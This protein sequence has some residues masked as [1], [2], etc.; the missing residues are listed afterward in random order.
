[1]YKIVDEEFVK[2]CVK[3][4]RMDSHKGENGVVLV[5]GGGW[6]YHGAPFL[7]A[8]A[9]LRCGV[10]LAY[11]AAPEKIVPSIRALSPAIIAIPLTDLKPKRCELYCG[12]RGSPIEELDEEPPCDECWRVE[13]VNG[14]LFCEGCGRWYPII[15]EI[16]RM[17]PDDLRDRNED[18]RFL[19]AWRARIPE[20]ILRE[21]KPF[22]L[23]G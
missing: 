9:A 11:I 22:S 8:M 6:M 20:R 14:I 19:A 12:Y 3:P 15:D 2:S 10:D 23:P 1:M 13:I 18:V 4:R 17:L 21:G 7:A 16:P 5:V